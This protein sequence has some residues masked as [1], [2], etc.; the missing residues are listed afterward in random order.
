MLGDYI[1]KVLILKLIHGLC[2]SPPTA[3]HFWPWKWRRGIL[4]TMLTFPLIPVRGERSHTLGREYVCERRG[5][6]DWKWISEQYKTL[7]KK[8]ILHFTYDNFP[9]YRVL[10]FS[11]K[12]GNSRWTRGVFFGK[13]LNI[14]YI[15]EKLI[16]IQIKIF[17]CLLLL[18]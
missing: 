1:K 15:Y 10:F 4:L 14:S 2:S 3:S 8:F 13:K 16:F 6:K 7:E 11:A 9:I 12:R 17:F 18:A 5:G